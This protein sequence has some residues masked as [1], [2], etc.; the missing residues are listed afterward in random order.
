TLCPASFKTSAMYSEPVLPASPCSA[1][2]RKRNCSISAGVHFGALISRAVSRISA[3]LFLR[4]WL[5]D[6]CLCSASASA[7]APLASPVS[8]S[9]PGAVA[10]AVGP[11]QPGQQPPVL[12]HIL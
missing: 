7:N 2:S 8:F 9:R 12:H 4:A 5:I 10:V 1:R 3:F 11:R 6:L